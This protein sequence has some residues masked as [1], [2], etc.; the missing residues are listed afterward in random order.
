[1]RVVDSGVYSSTRQTTINQA[2]QATVSRFYSTI[3]PRRLFSSL[4]RGLPVQTCYYF[5]Y[6]SVVANHRCRSCRCLTTNHYFSIS[7]LLRTLLSLSTSVLKQ[8]E[9]KRIDRNSFYRI[10]FLL[11]FVHFNYCCR[12]NR[13]NVIECHR[14]TYECLSVLFRFTRK[15]I[16]F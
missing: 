1:M 3:L 14:N 7:S 2:K 13:K 15:K 6:S 8:D 11:T 10:V 12:L 4:R 5:D 9:W 16:I